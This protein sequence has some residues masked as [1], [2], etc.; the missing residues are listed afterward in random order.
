MQF[1]VEWLQ[2]V[3][4]FADIFYN[5]YQNALPEL[6]V[7]GYSIAFQQWQQDNAAEII[8]LYEYCKQQNI[9]PNATNN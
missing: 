7:S 3:E 4:P 2:G 1:G 8:E 5:E 9:I 6:I